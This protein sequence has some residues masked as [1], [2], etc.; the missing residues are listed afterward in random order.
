MRGAHRWSAE[1]VFLILHFRGEPMIER[2]LA[3]CVLWLV[4]AGNNGYI[5]D[6]AAAGIS[7]HRRNRGAVPDTTVM[8]CQIAGL[9]IKANFPA[10]GII[11]DKVL[12]AE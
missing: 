8:Y 3:I 11:I 6:P 4:F 7:K 10:V 2:R 9:Y 1:P 5:H 12:F